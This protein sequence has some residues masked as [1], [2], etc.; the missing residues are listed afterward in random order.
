MACFDHGVVIAQGTPEQI[1][2]NPHVIS[3]YLGQPEE[4]F[5]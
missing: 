5:A 3:A 4:E 2:N 1:R